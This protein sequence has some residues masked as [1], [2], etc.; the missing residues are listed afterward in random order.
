MSNRPKLLLIEDNRAYAE[1]LK[2]ELSDGFEVK[3]CSKG[4]E[5]QKIIETSVPDLLIVDI[6]LSGESGFDVVMKLNEI[7]TIPVIYLT[8]KSGLANR[9]AGFT[10]GAE[11]FIPK[12]VDFREL[13]VRINNVIRRHALSQATIERAGIKLDF[14]ARKVFTSLNGQ[15][16][17]TVL[18]AT[19][20]NILSYF[21]RNPG[22]V[23]S[24]GQ[25]L[26]S[27]WQNNLNVNE[28]TVDAHVFSIRKKLGKKSMVI[29]SVFGL[30]YRFCE[31]A[32]ELSC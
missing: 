24:R 32:N 27:I 16:E 31:T 8:S 23:L 20:F 17:E 9:I 21:I 18:S 22:R 26:D 28:R 4:H 13:I 6:N 10:L 14:V 12:P 5:A 25:I 30:G 2:F 19:E 15:W 11:D 3:S 29:E 7:R 1:R